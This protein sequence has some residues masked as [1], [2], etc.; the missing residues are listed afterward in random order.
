MKINIHHFF[1]LLFFL[2]TFSGCFNQENPDNFSIKGKINGAKGQKIFLE[3]LTVNQ[4][5]RV[6]STVLGDD[7]SFKFSQLPTETGFYLLK[8][9]T[10]KFITLN[11]GKGEKNE[12][13][14]DLATFPAEY[15]IS[16]TSGSEL[17]HDYFTKTAINQQ[18]LDSLSQIF[19]Q[20]KNLENFYQIK[21]QLDSSFQVVFKNQQRFLKKKIA[22]NPGS[23]A[24]LLLLNQRFANK[25]LLDETENFDLFVSLD[26]N[27]FAK[28][29]TNSHVISHH[30]RVEKIKTEKDETAK[31]EAKLL[32]G[33]PAPILNLRDVSG[34]LASTS[35]LQNKVV[36]LNF[37]ASW[38]P[39]CRAAN[40]QL[41][42]IYQKY[43]SRGFEIY[44]VSFDTN[45]EIWK[46]SLEIDKIKW[47]NVFDLDGKN[48]AV[49][50]LYNLPENLP[51]F[52]LIGTD[53]KILAK[54]FSISELRNLLKEKFDK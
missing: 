3:E 34:K 26:S 19:V 4:L 14:A 50:K 25:I 37:W 33:N 7:G 5:N 6:D 40:L 28:Y 45:Q 35:A 51:Y 29:P 46:N 1:G 15:D 22:E 9:E 36:L 17:L 42:E 13:I 39:P 54:G 21:Q 11:L 48:S 30:E 12:I 27:L 44:A 47:I 8:L 10:G 18:K 43:Q 49:R 38:S 32:P 23:V 41:K 20:S 31:A 2:L 16:G 53:G 52:Y 24:S